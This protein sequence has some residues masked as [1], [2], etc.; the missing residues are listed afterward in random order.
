MFTTGIV[1]PAKVGA[2]G[3]VRCARRPVV[4]AFAGV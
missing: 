1:A 3:Y 2:H 4:P